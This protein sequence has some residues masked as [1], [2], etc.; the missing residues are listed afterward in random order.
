MN[1]SKYEGINPSKLLQE[2]DLYEAPVDLDTLCEKLGVKKSS[3]MRFSSHSGE[4]KVNSDGKVNIWI[5]SMD[6][7]NRRRFTLAHELGHLVHDIIPYIRTEE[8]VSEFIDDVST[9]RR[10]GRQHPEEYRANDFAA[11]LLMPRKLI[12]KY[13]NEIIKTMQKKSG[14]KK[15]PVDN[16]ITEMALKFKVSEQAMRIRLENIEAI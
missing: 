5:N 7:P 6:S 16:F 12:K 2:F 13:G 10:D 8:G 9:L 14:K 15:V 1:L 11:R 3:K 4:I